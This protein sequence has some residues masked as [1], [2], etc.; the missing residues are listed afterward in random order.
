MQKLTHNV[1]S[2]SSIEFALREFY[3][4]T[5]RAASTTRDGAT[6]Q[7]PSHDIALFN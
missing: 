7:R 2:D 6:N 4:G 5:P 3:A 1:Q